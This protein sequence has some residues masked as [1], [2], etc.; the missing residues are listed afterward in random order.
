V[1]RLLTATLILWGAAAAQQPQ[2]KMP[3]YGLA[4]KWPMVTYTGCLDYTRIHTKEQY[5]QCEE[6]YLDGLIAKWQGQAKPGG[7]T[8][9]SGPRDRLETGPPA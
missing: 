3:A 5:L 6:P 4:H 9:V 1:K 7:K 8:I 2:K